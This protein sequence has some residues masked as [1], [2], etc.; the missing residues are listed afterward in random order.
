MIRS[1][2]PVSATDAKRIAGTWETVY[3]MGLPG[4]SQGFSAQAMAHLVPG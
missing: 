3:V 1:I 4:S 2:R